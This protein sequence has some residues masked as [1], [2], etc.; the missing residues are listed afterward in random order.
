[1]PAP[2]VIPAPRAYID[3]VAVKGFVVGARDF[4]WLP[5]LRR[6]KVAFPLL[7]SD[8]TEPLWKFL[9]ELMQ[10]RTDRARGVR[11]ITVNKTACP[12]QPLTAECKSM[13]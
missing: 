7:A 4:G 6:Q 3:A 8:G 1:M 5:P 2:A 10:R 11:R 9:R 12:R 13:E